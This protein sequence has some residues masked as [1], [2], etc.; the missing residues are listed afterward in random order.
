MRIPFR[1]IPTGV[2][3][4][5][6]LQWL[7]GT[8]KKAGLPPGTPVYIGEETAEKPRI[9]LMSY[10]SED[11]EEKELEKIDDAFS[12]KDKPGTH[13]LNIDGLHRVEIIEAICNHLEV[14]PLI[15]EDIVHTGQRPKIEDHEQYVYIVLRMLG[16]DDEHRG[17]EDEQ[18]SLILGPNY[19][20]SFQEK[21]GDIFNPIRERIRSG[22][23]RMRK[24]GADYLA[25]A[26]IDTIVDNYFAVIEKMGEEIEDLED[27]VTANPSDENLHTIQKLKREN[28][29]LRKSIWP[30]REVVNTLTRGDVSRVED[31]T[32]VFMKD[33]HDHII[34]VMDTIETFRDMVAGIMDIYLSALSNRMN[35]IMKVLT[36]IAT[37]FIPLTFIT[38]VY[39]MNFKHMPELEHPYG[40]P[41]VI[42][43]M[44]LL[45][46]LM[47]IFFKRRKWL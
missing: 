19:V 23:S 42:G 16:Y 34:H 28:L 29:Y 18:V 37:I 39:G 36:V 21:V 25:Y 9:T 12:F 15:T 40:Y 26:L 8:S 46:L 31:S 44:I 11:Y 17:L 4:T 3:K 5:I 43:F 41:A 6:A 22:K 45:G 35:E 47:F 24:M 14:H 20:I 7:V 10:T 32:A 13:W 27:T 33:V 38:G 30:L 1:K 2:K